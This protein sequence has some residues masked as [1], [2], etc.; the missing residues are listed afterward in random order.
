MRVLVGLWLCYRGRGAEASLQ[1]PLT[2]MT[3]SGASSVALRLE[4][5]D[6]E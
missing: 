5:D 4:A 3:P 1:R 2:K 6:D